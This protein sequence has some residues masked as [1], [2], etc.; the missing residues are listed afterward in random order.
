M[1]AAGSDVLVFRPAVIDLDA[2]APDIQTAGRSHTFTTTAGTATLYLELYDSVTGDKLAW[3]M[4]GIAANNNASFMTMSNS[5]TNTQ[6]AKRAMRRWATQLRDGLDE[7]KE[8]GLP[9]IE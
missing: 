9:K 7:V 2:N 4:H 8:K 6:A 5:V 3:L 1:E